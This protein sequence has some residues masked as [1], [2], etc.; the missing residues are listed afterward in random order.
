MQVHAE[1]RNPMFTYPSYFVGTS[2]LGRSESGMPPS[3]RQEP[4]SMGQVNA[5]P[6]FKEQYELE[7]ERNRGNEHILILRR[8]V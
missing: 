6:N 3:Y 5:P 2:A 4:K 7:L 1:T 8:Y